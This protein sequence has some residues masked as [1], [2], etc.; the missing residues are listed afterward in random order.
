MAYENYRFVSWAAK[1]PITGDRLAQM[2]TNIEQVKDATS[3]SPTGIIKFKQVTSDFPSSTGYN[4][5]LEYDMIQLKDESPSGADN[6]V[7]IN[8]NRYYRL[9]LTFPGIVVKDKGAEDS[10]FSLKLYRGLS[11]GIPTLITTWKMTPSAYDYFDV[12][13]GT[14]VTVTVP[15]QV[16]YPTIFGAGT[17][18]M[19]L[20]SST[21]LTNE[22]F[23]VSIK[24]DQGASAN[25][26]PYYYVGAGGSAM[27]MYVEDIG[28]V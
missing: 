11:T 10:S 23:Y 21:G 27:Q 9:T 22:S 2:S 26:A 1:T 8:A 16:G 5:F 17:Y 4:T 14:S 6:R 25:N 7:T 28:G 24:R 18:S 12:S 19:V 20:D 13:A 15:K 3:D